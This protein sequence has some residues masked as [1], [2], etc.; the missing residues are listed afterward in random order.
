MENHGVARSMD[1]QRP[2]PYANLIPVNGIRTF[3]KFVSKKEE[4]N[5]HH[6]KWARFFC[7]NDRNIQTG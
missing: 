2:A 3:T 7:N 1:K 5:F 4:T 6:T